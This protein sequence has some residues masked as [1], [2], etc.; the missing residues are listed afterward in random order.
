M[1]D[2]SFLIQLNTKKRK[3]MDLDFYPEGET[4]NSIMDCDPEFIRIWALNV[5]HQTVRKAS[6]LILYKDTDIIKYK[7]DLQEFVKD[8]D[9]YKEKLFDNIIDYIKKKI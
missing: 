3:C 2:T 5:A 1:T 6:M 8:L 4:P 7:K 9:P